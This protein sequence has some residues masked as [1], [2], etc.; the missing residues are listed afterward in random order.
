MRSTNISRVSNAPPAVDAVERVAVVAGDDRLQRELVGLLEHRVVRPGG[1]GAGV[2]VHLDRHV[3]RD[4]ACARRAVVVEAG[5]ALVQAPHL[6]RRPRRPR[7]A[8]PRCGRRGTARRRP[9]GHRRRC[10]RRRRTRGSRSHER[11]RAWAGMVV[12][13]RADGPGD[14][15]DEERLLRL[16]APVGRLGRLRRRAVP[17]AAARAA[18]LAAVG[19]AQRPGRD[20]HARHAAAQPHPAT[21]GRG[22]VDAPTPRSW[23]SRSTRRS[24]SSA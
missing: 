24:S 22:V 7:P 14:A 9:P 19:A 4:V 3:G 20:D 8:R 1:R 10:A 21:A 17:R 2:V 11:C 16:G 6:R 5:G 18:R 13:R 15:F 23:T 12:M